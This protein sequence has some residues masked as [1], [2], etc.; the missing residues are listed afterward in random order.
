VG[1][2]EIFITKGVTMKKKV[3][4]AVQCAYDP[5][6]EFEKVFEIE[7]DVENQETK[8]EA[9]CP[10]CDKRVTITIKG[11]VIPDGEIL[12]KFNLS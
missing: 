9:F 4:Y 3:I 12:R 5:K 8:V 10:F 11:K 6:H 2:F 7:D 1:W